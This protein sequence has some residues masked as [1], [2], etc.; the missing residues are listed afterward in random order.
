MIIGDIN[1]PLID[2]NN[3]SCEGQGKEF[4]N[5]CLDFNFNQ[6]VDFPTHSRNNILDLV[7]SNDE[8]ILSVDNLGPLGNSDH[9]MLLVVTNHEVKH[10]TTTNVRYN[11]RKADYDAM[12]SEIN[13]IK[14]DEKLTGDIEQNWNEFK[15]LI[16]ESIEKHVPKIT[17]DHL[18]FNS[19][20]NKS[21]HGFMKSRS[22]QTNLLE[23]MDFEDVQVKAV[24]MISGLRSNDYQGKLA[25]L[26]LWSLAKRREMYDLVG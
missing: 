4:L 25:E 13:V 3:L 9:V 11:W 1:Y 14:W 2:W 23:F 7:L 17:T 19:L 26:N 21:Q 20:L 24:R 6:Y 10:E 18:N 15:K 22:C 12:K 8:S 16:N 5:V